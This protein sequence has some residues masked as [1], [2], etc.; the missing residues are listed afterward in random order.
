M[1]HET[2]SRPSFHMAIRSLASAWGTS[3]T[4]LLLRHTSLIYTN[5]HLFV[6]AASPRPHVAI[7]Q[8]SSV[9]CYVTGQHFLCAAKCLFQNN[10]FW[11]RLLIFHLY[12]STK[13]SFLSTAAFSG[14]RTV[15]F[16]INTRV[17][18]KPISRR[19]LGYPSC[20]RQPV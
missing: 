4:R 10:Y 6:F 8:S 16:V 20:V 15:G 3:S 9:G 18:V 13:L 19:R 5:S 7:L 12:Y 14:N 1:K 17:S 2:Q 11:L